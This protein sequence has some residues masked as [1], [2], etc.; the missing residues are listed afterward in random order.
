MDM[1][2]VLYDRHIDGVSRQKAPFE[3]QFGNDI[4]ELFLKDP[5]EGTSAVGRVIT[6][7]G[8]ISFGF[9]IYFQL[10]VLVFESLSD[11]KN[12]NVRNGG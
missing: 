3:D 6:L 9:G 11:G 10:K 12:L 1:Q 8:Q 7:M 2:L 5:L 4:D